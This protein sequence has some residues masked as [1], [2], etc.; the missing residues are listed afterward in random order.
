MQKYN[1]SLHDLKRSYD[2][3]CSNWHKCNTN[4]A[5]SVQCPKCA[6]DSALLDVFCWHSLQKV[7]SERSPR[8]SV[9][10]KVEE[11][12]IIQI[13]D[14]QH[15]LCKLVNYFDTV[16]I[17]LQHCNQTMLIKALQKK[18][19]SALGGN[20]GYCLKSDSWMEI[21]SSRSWVAIGLIIK[22]L[23][24]TSVVSNLLSVNSL[25]EFMYSEPGLQFPRFSSFGR[26]W[27]TVVL[28]NWANDEG[29]RVLPKWH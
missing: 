6:D 26:G 27:A 23:M 21:S 25:Q 7:H 16:Q 22:T 2:K 8:I 19:T 18:K 17:P 29:T 9:K 15:I 4:A 24:S 14:D 10:K 1:P 5:L 11:I 28:R 12:I 3:D 13:F 20:D